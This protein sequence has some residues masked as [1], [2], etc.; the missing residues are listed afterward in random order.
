MKIQSK[1]L[2]MVMACGLVI[3]LASTGLAQESLLRVAFSWPTFFDPAVGNDFSSSSAIVNLYD[4]LVYPLA[5]GIIPNAAESWEVST[6]NLTYTFQ[7]RKGIKF[8]SGNEMTA[9]DVKFSMDRL[10]EIGEGY[11]YLYLG[12]I[13][14]TDVIDEYT[15]SF[16]LKTPFGPFVSSLVRLYI[17]EKA[18]VMA[19]L[20]DGFYGSFGDYGKGYLLSNDA[21][22][23][24]YMVKEV[25]LGEYIL[26]EKFPGYWGEVLPNAPDVV[27]FMRSPD[28]IAVKTMMARRELEITTPWEPEE[29][30]QEMAKIPGVEVVGWNSGFSEYMMLNNQK[31]PTDCIH[32]RR[33]LNWMLD[34]EQVLTGIYPGWTQAAGPIAQNLP[35]FKEGLFQYYQDMDKAREELQKSKYADQL[36]GLKVTLGVD[37]TVPPREQF[38]LMLQ[39]NAAEFGIDVEIIKMTWG[40]V[41]EVVGSIETTPN[42]MHI[43]VAPHYPEAG[44]MLAAKYHSSSAGTWEQ[45]EHL[46]S[47]VIDVLIDDAL[48]TVDQDERFQKYGLLQEV[49]V[50]L[51]PSMFLFDVLEKHAYQEAYVDWSALLDNPRPTMGYN[52]DCRYIEVYP[53]RIP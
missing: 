6:D 21:G 47:P 17:L 31:P 3:G 26:M 49:L 46:L 2:L 8:H 13:D 41:Q 16:V 22:S 10:L 32:F 40:K 12:K 23:G 9:E 30:Y 50:E 4:A 27:K 36:E 48:G 7:L 24:P 43:N 25:G 51:S 42:G 45:A 37:T 29:A 39:A 53:D 44:S 20:K 38:A 33:A 1:I 5:E 52:Y 28:T 34:W 19:N 35:G 14:H 15:V 11:A 18:V